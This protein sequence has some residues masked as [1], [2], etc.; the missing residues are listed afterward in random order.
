MRFKLA[1]LLCAIGALSLSSCGK[2][3]LSSTSTPA[4]QHTTSVQTQTDVNAANYPQLLD[5][6]TKTRAAIEAGDTQKAQQ[7]FDQFEGAWSQVEDGIKDKSP[8]SYDAIEGD[9]DQVTASLRA[10]DS[11]KV[12]EA[13]QALDIHIQSIPTS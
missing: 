9:M 3:Q 7:E 1:I 11:T 8:D 2:T 4:E 13:L 10:S 6:V 5:V 12:L